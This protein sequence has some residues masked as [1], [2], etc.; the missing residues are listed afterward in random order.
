LLLRFDVCL[1]IVNGRRVE[2]NETVREVF[3]ICGDA[4]IRFISRCSVSTIGLGVA[5]GATSACQE[6]ASKA[7]ASAASANVGTS[8]SAP[9]R[10]ADVTA[11]AR[12]L[13][14]LPPAA[15]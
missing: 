15:N 12:S 14:Y 11:S 2:R 7:D 5:A 8:G 10:P 1:D 13:S 3:T 9:S 6:T 4:M